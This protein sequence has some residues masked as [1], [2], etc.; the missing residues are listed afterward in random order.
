MGG[1]GVEVAVDGGGVID[2]VGGD[3]VN[4]SVREGADVSVGAAVG[5]SVSATDPLQADKIKLPN[6]NKISNPRILIARFPR[7]G[8]RRHLAAVGGNPW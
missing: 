2:A 1:S 5:V 3:G 4:V 6:S 7:C 8:D